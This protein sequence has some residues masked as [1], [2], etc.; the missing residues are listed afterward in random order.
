MDD[1]DDDKTS[2]QSVSALVSSE[3]SGRQNPYLIVLSGTSVGRMF[4]IQAGEMLIGRSPD[5]DIMLDDDGVSR[6]H[7]RLICTPDGKVKILDLGSTNGTWVE[8]SRVDFHGLQDGDRIQIGSATIL[9]YGY[10]DSVEEQFVS[11]LYESATQDG[12][13]GLHNKRYF[14]EALHKE[15]AWH[16][17]HGAPL[18][19]ILFDIDFFK[20]INDTYGHHAGDRVLMQVAQTCKRQLRTEDLLARY[21][22]EEFACILRQT[23]VEQATVV[24]ERVRRAV[25]STVFESE[26]SDG[27]RL[28]IPVTISVGVAGLSPQLSDEAALIQ[29]ADHF[30]YEAKRG[31]RN[32]VESEAS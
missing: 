9:K 27:S 2:I 11:Q 1:D 8:G 13:T 28:R 4:K 16:R 12:L 5:C 29:R 30:L 18:T 3:G 23:T 6:K 22:G 14:L 15:F 7:A 25:E 19:L 10:Q 26:H 32:R 17:R 20:K 21:G 31:G 24:A